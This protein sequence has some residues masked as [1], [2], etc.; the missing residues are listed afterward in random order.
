MPRETVQEVCIQVPG[1]F[2]VPELYLTEGPHEVAKALT[3]GAEAYA[4][5]TKKATDLVRRETHAEAVK[6]ATQDY[7]RRLEETQAAAE[8][9]ARKLKKERVQLEEALAAAQARIDALEQSAGSLRSAA[10]KEA[11]ETYQELLAT[12]EEQ[13]ARL[14]KTLEKQLEGVTSRVESLQN[15][16]TKTFASSKEKGSLG[17][18]IVEAMLKKAFDCD[19][20]VVS[21]DAQTADI[22]MTRGPDCEIFWEVKN[23]TR[24]VSTE[25]VEKF[26]RDLRLHPGVRGGCLVSLRTGIV[27]RSR[28][29]DIDI[30][31][32]EDG[33][34]VLFLSNFMSR[35]DPIFYLQTLRPLFQTIETLSKPVQQESEAVAALQAKAALITN[36]LRSHCA[37]VAKHR[38]SLVTHKKRSDA[39]FMEFQGYVLE[40]ETQL[41]TLLRIAMGAGTGTGF[42]GDAEDA[43]REAETHL[44]SLVFTKE[45]LS[46]LEGRTKAFVAWLLEAT[47]AREGTQLEVK[48]LLE[49]A[50]EKGFGEKFVRELREDVFQPVA[51]AR[52]ARHI[53]G[54]RWA[55]TVAAVTSTVIASV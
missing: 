42:A 2:V 53:L 21:K 11:R 26:R 48:E 52:G 46:D 3:L 49:R 28:G 43:Q 38:N 34:F 36:L 16:I 37:A 20:S 22:R 9:A 30:E 54:L 55:S 18:T 31:F 17:E 6:E 10:Q 7:E 8:T 14:Q 51:W 27:G 13:I 35:E 23:Y 5:L 25:E 4:L 39:M 45:R 12:K 50:K 1:S 44:S 32:L 15:S 40:A 41:Q 29:G 24:M 47:E 33:R 19:V